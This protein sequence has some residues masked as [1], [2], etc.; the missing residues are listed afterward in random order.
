MIRKA[1]E[2]DL[3]II[4]KIGVE[5][6]PNFIKL[7]HID[8]EINN[9]MAIVLVND[10]DNAING[11]LYALDFE[12]NLDL[13]Y[14]IV[15]ESKRNMQIGSK[16]MKYFVENYQVINKTIT[17]EVAI[18]NIPAIKLYQKFNFYEVNKRKGYYHGV[19][20]LIMRRD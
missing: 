12:D 18:N 9:K 16:L 8:T 20:A 14:I 7:F 11:F 13:L 17:L 3:A 10:E 19:D 1:K 15:D 2:E 6:N 5:Y 4:N